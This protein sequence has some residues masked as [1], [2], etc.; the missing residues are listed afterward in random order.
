MKLLR[1]SKWVALPLA[2]AGA[3]V[4]CS[5]TEQ[6]APAPAAV[7][8]VA[9]T[10][11]QKTVPVQVNAIGTVEAYSTVSVKSQITGELMAVH[12]RE[13][14]EVKRGDPLFTIDERPFRVAVEQ[15]QANMT[16]DQAQLENARA[17]ARRY[18]SLFEEGVVAKEK[19]DQVRTQADALEAVVKADQAAVDQSQLNLQYCS[20]AAPLDGRTGSLIVHRGN[21]VKANDDPPLVVINQLAPIYVNFSIPQQY[22]SVVKQKMGAGSLKVETIVPDEPGRREE[23]TLSFIDNSVDSATGT[24]RLKATYPNSDR[25]LWPGQFVNVILTLS[26]QP[27]AV[28]VPSQAIQK[29]QEGSYIYVI[30]ANKTVDARSVSPGMTYEGWTVVEKGLSPGETVVTD[31]QL[32]LTPGMRVE[33]KPAPES[34]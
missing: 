25:R 20:I 29:S 14:D 33:I 10:A 19:F 30:K 22:L 31:G 9:A 3:A 21:Q 34:Q 23:G 28:V 8:V 11:E 26:E 24:I 16:R 6:A 27:N 12:F 5:H 7:P 32:R 15:A 18:A 17:E 13:G 4:G 2:L 1:F